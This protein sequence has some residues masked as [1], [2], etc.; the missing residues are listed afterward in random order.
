MGIYRS[1]KEAIIHFTI[2]EE[3]PAEPENV[4][5]KKITRAKKETL[6][7]QNI[8]EAIILVRVEEN[9]ARNPEN[10]YRSTSNRMLRI[11]KTRMSP[12][13]CMVP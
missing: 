12:K 5:I 4:N 7:P 13:W 3:G 9:A 11:T 1:T 6:I 2:G 8:Q 10:T